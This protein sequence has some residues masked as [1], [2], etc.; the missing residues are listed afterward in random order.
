M[1][2]RAHTVRPGGNRRHRRTG[3]ATH[4]HS[5]RRTRPA[6]HHS[7][8]HSRTRPVTSRKHRKQGM[9]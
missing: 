1:T 6:T 5:H 3:P 2:G 4:H 7:H 8:R 9:S